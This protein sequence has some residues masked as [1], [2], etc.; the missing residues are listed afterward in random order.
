[1]TRPFHAALLA[2]TVLPGAS[3]LA[4]QTPAPSVTL[5][6]AGRSLVR[7]SLPL[8]IPAG[9]SLHTLELGLFDISSFAVLDPGVQVERIDVDATFDENSLLRRHVGDVFSFIPGGGKPVIRARLLAL[10]PERWLVL[11]GDLSDMIPNV[12]T[13]T[14]PGRLVWD[15][16]FVPSA[17]VADLT[18]M[19]DRGRDRISVMYEAPGGAWQAGYRLFVGRASRFEGTATMSAGRLALDNVEVQLL[20]GDIGSRSQDRYPAPAMYAS[21]KVAMMSAAAM[22]SNEAVGD[23]R[24]YTVPGRVSFTPG[25]QSAVPLFAPVTVQPER[26][27]TVS[28]SLPFYG[29]IG[30]EQDEAEFPVGVSYRIAHALRTPFG[31]LALPAGM[32]SVYDTDAGGRV[33]LVGSG[34]IG[35]T[36]PGAE[37]EVATG[38]AFDVTAHRVQT[39]YTTVRTGQPSRTVATIGYRVRIAN[40]KD[41]AITVE[42]REDRGGEWSVLSSSVPAVRRSASR[43]TFALPVPAKGEATLTYRVRVVW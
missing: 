12:V 21:E 38:S 18:V 41:S 27:L 9:R 43:T 20:A 24:L 7:R 42:V 32:V 6:S 10:D 2:L 36:A 19:S 3:S 14:R 11:P 39:E 28:G 34:T 13:F 40:A 30:Q 26:R 25:V 4:A 16:S 5:F 1:M 29:G 37:V 8:T 35:H 17:P 15:S 23:A 22:P 33:Q 31:D